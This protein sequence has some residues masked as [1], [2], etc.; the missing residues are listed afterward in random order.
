MKK[1]PR[2][3]KHCHHCCE[4]PVPPEP[5][6]LPPPICTLHVTPPRSLHHQILTT[7]VFHDFGNVFAGIAGVGILLMCVQGVRKRMNQGGD[8]DSSDS[9]DD[10]RARP[11]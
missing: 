3:I 5:G 9:E 6:C 7:S 11:N 10:A 2:L 4:R 8:E 1:D